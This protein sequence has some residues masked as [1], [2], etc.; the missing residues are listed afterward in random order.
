MIP[1]PKNESFHFDRYYVPSSLH[2]PE[3]PLDNDGIYFDIKPDMGVLTAKLFN[4]SILASKEEKSPYVLS[5][6][7][8]KA[9]HIINNFSKSPMMIY[10]E[11]IPI[12]DVPF[13]HF[14]PP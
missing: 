13:L 2:P 8:F 4:P 6:W 9:F 11:D 12:L 1:F 7:G 5:Y 14:Y 3:K 10:G